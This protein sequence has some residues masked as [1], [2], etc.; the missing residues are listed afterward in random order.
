MPNE[1]PI[2]S[3]IPEVPQEII[4]A[5]NDKNLL[6][7]IGAGV[8]RIVGGPSWEILA[9]KLIGACYGDGEDKISYFECEEVK[10]N[11]PKKIISIAKRILGNSQYREKVKEFLK[12]DSRK[13][14]EYPIYD[15]IYRLRATYLTTNVDDIFDSKFRT[16]THLK[17]HPFGMKADSIQPLMLCHVHGSINSP[18]TLIL[19]VAE[20]LEH[21][22]DKPWVDDLLVP[23]FKNNVV[24]FIGYG[25]EE[26]EILENII[27]KSKSILSQAFKK[28]ILLPFYSANQNVFRHEKNF[29]QEMNVEAIGY[30]IDK[31]VIFSCS[32]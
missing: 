23:L 17:L 8:S 22:S 14:E 31:K 16:E 21:Y 9:Q 4:D 26:T 19:T 27:R 29:Y 10:K 5:V 18:D 7:F 12:P 28:F 30:S 11:N 24:L 3:E 15:Y 1:K 6:V 25:M 20:Y 13:T 32:M 2:I